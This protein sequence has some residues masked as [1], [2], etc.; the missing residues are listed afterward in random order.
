MAEK[1]VRF[2][3]KCYFFAIKA[4]CKGGH[5]DEVFTYFAL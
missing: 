4:L 3:G 2:S 5:L 1:D